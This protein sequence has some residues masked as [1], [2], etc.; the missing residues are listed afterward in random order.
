MSTFCQSSAAIW[1]IV[2]WF[3]FVVKIVI[4]IILI[5]LGMLDLGKAVVSSDDKAI[6]KSAK[7]FLMRVI[8]AIAV[9]LIPTVVGLVFKMVGNWTDAQAQYD[10]CRICITSP[11][12]CDISGTVDYNAPA[13]T[14]DTTKTS[15]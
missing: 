12:K 5:I 6:Q 13:T 7:S 4:P 9:F 14:T 3:L 15:K 2:G 10:V 8:A 1:Q 11:S